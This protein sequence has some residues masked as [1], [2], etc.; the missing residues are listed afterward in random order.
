LWGVP[1]IWACGFLVWGILRM[2]LRTGG[3]DPDDRRSVAIAEQSVICMGPLFED[4]IAGGDGL[5][6]LL[7][8]GWAN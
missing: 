1:Q 5:G 6:K 7:A 4:P 3:V 8:D 2:S